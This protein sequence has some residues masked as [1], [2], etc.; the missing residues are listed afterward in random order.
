MHRM[1]FEEVDY[2]EHSGERG[3]EVGGQVSIERHA[4]HFFLRIA[5]PRRINTWGIV[6]PETHFVFLL[7]IFRFASFST[8]LTEI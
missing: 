4:M 3:H 7:L 1:T 6:K 2:G 5:I 8:K